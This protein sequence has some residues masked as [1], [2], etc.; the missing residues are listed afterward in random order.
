VNDPVSFHVATWVASCPEL[1]A[2]RVVML[3]GSG[4]NNHFHSAYAAGVHNYLVKP[5]DTEGFQQ[6]STALK[7]ILAESSASPS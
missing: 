2:L 4:D 5:N 6:L 1:K 3:T 7:K